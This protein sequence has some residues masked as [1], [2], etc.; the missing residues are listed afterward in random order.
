M[1]RLTG[2]DQMLYLTPRIDDARTVLHHAG[3]DAGTGACTRG[4]SDAVR[5]PSSGGEGML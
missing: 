3:R 2:E 1:S 5:P 4:C